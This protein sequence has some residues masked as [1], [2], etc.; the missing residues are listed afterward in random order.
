MAEN[1]GIITARNAVR[2]STVCKV[3]TEI[4][5]EASRAILIALIWPD[6]HLFAL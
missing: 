1:N 5:K 6:H 4:K 3:E 2:E